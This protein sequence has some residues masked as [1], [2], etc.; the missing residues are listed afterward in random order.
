[1]TD[2]NK[3]KSL[4]GIVFLAGAVIL[5]GCG[6]EPYEVQDTEREIIVNYAAHIVS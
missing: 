3:K 4:L 5:G 1:M 2:L 6:E